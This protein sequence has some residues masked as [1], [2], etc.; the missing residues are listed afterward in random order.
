MMRF[1]R[2]LFVFPVHFSLQIMNLCFWG[3]LI[4]ALGLIKLIPIGFFRQAINPVIAHFEIAFGVCNITL[5]R[6][7]NQIK[8]DYR[9]TTALAKDQWYL[10]TVNHRSYLD[11]ILVMDFAYQRIPAPK[12]FLK[13]ELIWLPVVGL[14][15]WALDMPFMQR[16][17][18][19]QITKNPS[20]AG[21]DIE[22]TRKQ[23]EK[24]KRTPTTVVNFAEGTRFTANKHKQKLSPF[25]HLLRPK[26]GG[27]AFTLNTMGDQFTQLLDMTLIYPE[28]S[29]HPMMDMLC[30]N[31][32]QIIVD[33]NSVP[34]TH[35]LRGNYDSD[36]EFKLH[37]QQW[38]NALWAKKD[39]R[40]ESYLH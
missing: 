28:N 1:L 35:D 26:A 13:K 32:K 29:D 20:L 2:A 15:A 5:L 30:G 14:G 23:C 33:V 36:N 34:I 31:M 10:V 19:A 39:K 37:F 40:I 24:Y 18:Q 22:T 25:T 3:G 9:I 4:I 17:S 6:F 11:V 7:F 8:I 16:F 27:L 12:F 21:T 38:L